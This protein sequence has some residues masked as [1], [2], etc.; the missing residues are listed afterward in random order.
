M[1]KIRF[2]KHKRLPVVSTPAA[3][4]IIGDIYEYQETEETG[5]TMIVDEDELTPE[6]IDTISN[7]GKVWKRVYIE[8]GIMI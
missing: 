1:R 5:K 7:S 6:E 2:F 3:G 4:M 8:P